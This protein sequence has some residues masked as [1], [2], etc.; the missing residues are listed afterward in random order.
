MGGSGW[1]YAWRASLWTLLTA[2]TLGLALPWREAALERYKMRHT[3]YGDVAGAFT[4]TGW[5]LF[6]RGWW[7]WLLLLVAVTAPFAYAGYEFGRMH[8]T[9]SSA[10]VAG[11]A[12]GM[13]LARSGLWIAMLF[14]IPLAACLIYPA[15]KA[16]LWRWWVDGI[17]FGEV[18]FES[19]FG[20]KSIFGLY[21]KM[22]GW[23][24]FISAIDGAVIGLAVAVW[25]K[26]SG[27]GATAAVQFSQSHPLLS[28]AAT[29]ANYILLAL[30]LGIVMR[31]YLLRDLWAR[32]VT[33]TTVHNLDAVENVTVHGT[34]ADAIGE[35]F[36]DSFDVV[37]F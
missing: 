6:K 3:Y 8:P 10:G 27:Q 2:L 19:S 28:L 31:V 29:M 5:Q 9:A 23:A 36:G 13:M 15:Y 37:G 11:A 16:R 7:L 17:R 18:R 30:A 34:A 25:V 12:V 22:F 20:F 26:V 4:G 24:F 21:A 35:G 1:S 33:T 32:I 14:A